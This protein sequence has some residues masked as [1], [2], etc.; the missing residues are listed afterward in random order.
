MMSLA[1]LDASSARSGHE[2]YHEK[3]FPHRQSCEVRHKAD[4][5]IAME[6]SCKA[7]RSSCMHI[8]LKM[9]GLERHALYPGYISLRGFLYS[10]CEAADAFVNRDGND[11]CLT[12]GERESANLD[13]TNYTSCR[14]KER[15]RGGGGGGGGSSRSYIRQQCACTCAT[16]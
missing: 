15:R 14:T 11:G 3:A 1:R 4:H 8:H 2:L 9:P 10:I 6:T 13:D 5:R 12:V 16:V 7:T